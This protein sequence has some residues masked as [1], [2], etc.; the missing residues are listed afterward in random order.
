[1]VVW[2]VGGKERKGNAAMGAICV[3]EHLHFTYTK[4]TNY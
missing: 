2:W 3:Q 1:M 4:Q